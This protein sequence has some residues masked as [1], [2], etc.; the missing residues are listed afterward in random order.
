MVCGRGDGGGSSPRRMFRRWRNR[1][2]NPFPADLLRGILSAEWG[3]WG[4]GAADLQP[5]GLYAEPLTL[6][7]KEVRP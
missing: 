1:L 6:S 4:V 5:Q 7:P 3:G 2:G